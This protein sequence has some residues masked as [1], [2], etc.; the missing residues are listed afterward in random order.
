MTLVVGALCSSISS[1][2]CFSAAVLLFLFKRKSKAIFRLEIGLCI[3]LGLT[4]LA[5]FVLFFPTVDSHHIPFHI[6]YGGRIIT[7]GTTT[8]YL[9]AIF[10]IFL[11]NSFGWSEEKMKN[12][13]KWLHVFAWS[14]SSVS[15]VVFVLSYK[16]SSHFFWITI[17]VLCLEATFIIVCSIVVNVRQRKVFQKHNEILSP[18]ITSRSKKAHDSFLRRVSGLATVAVLVFLQAF[19][20]TTE[21]RDMVDKIT[22]TRYVSDLF[23]LDGLLISIMLTTAPNLIASYKKKL[24]HCTN[25]YSHMPV[26]P[27][28]Q[29]DVSI[30]S[31]ETQ[32][33]HITALALSSK[34]VSLVQ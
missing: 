7:L 1:I 21:I 29:I 34:N 3:A 31:P 19:L 9:V 24:A 15:F 16:A 26:S 12:V 18:L 2:A 6:L 33:A 8:H 10:I 17:F 27:Y 25:K 20:S 14:L 4:H 5:S 11:L 32:R 28:F 30:P 22:R 13:E 23:L